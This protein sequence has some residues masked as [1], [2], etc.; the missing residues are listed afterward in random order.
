M[1]RV[2]LAAVLLALSPA[3]ALSQEAGP[4]GS[5][6]S[7]RQALDGEPRFHGWQG[8]KP[9]VDCTCRHKE[10]RAELGDT[11]C[12]LQGSQRVTA[13]CQMVLNNPTWRV[14]RRH[15]DEPSS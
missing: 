15:C 14:L 6:G 8:P 13:Q 3:A 1:R 12:I 10:G 2:L 7:G 9:V 4:N 11:V 5:L